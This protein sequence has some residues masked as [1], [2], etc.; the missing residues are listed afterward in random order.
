[1]TENGSSSISDPFLWDMGSLVF[2]LPKNMAKTCLK[3]ALLSE[4]FP[5]KSCFPPYMS[6]SKAPLYLL[7][8]P[9]H[10]SLTESN[11]FIIYLI[12]SWSVVLSRS[13]LTIMLHSCLQIIKMN[14]NLGCDIDILN[15][16]E[17]Q[18]HYFKPQSRFR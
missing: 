13:K 5:T 6:Q 2:W 4:T 18:S 10:L 14:I 16:M 9:P 1:M 7:L 3:T 17:D 15:G 8:F 11:N 12:A